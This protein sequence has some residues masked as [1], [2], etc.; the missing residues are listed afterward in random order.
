M[1]VTREA[2][3][4][5]S[6]QYVISYP[7]VTDVGDRSILVDNLRAIDAGEV[8]VEPTIYASLSGSTEFE[9]VECKAEIIDA[10]HGKVHT[11]VK[12]LRGDVIDNVVWHREGAKPK[13]VK[14][15]EKKPKKIYLLAEVFPLP[16]GE[17]RF[18]PIGVFFK[19]KKAKEWAEELTALYEFS[20][21]GAGSIDDYPIT[22]TWRTDKKTGEMSLHS[23]VNDV[24]IGVVQFVIQQPLTNPPPRDT[25]AEVDAE[26]ARRAREDGDEKSAREIESRRADRDGR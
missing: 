17:R 23:L 15:K 1:F 12:T 2:K 6:P 8:S 5:R 9:E 19:L 25:S 14:R 11:A 18:T 10:K 16:E 22:F 4:S 20:G 13:P 26:Y 3:A 7:T 21:G 24:P